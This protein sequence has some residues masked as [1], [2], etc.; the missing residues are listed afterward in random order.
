M[1]RSQH[2]ATTRRRQPPALTRQALPALASFLRGYL[3]QDYAEE[4]GSAEAAARAFREAASAEEL[5]ALE[6][7]LE[8]FARAVADL[9]FARVR[10]LLADELGSAWEPASRK[11]LDGLSAA[12]RHSP[13]AS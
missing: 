9:P 6:A 13:S 8:A 3:H 10:R 11:E 4:H 1:K 5:E 7:D 2:T 12:L